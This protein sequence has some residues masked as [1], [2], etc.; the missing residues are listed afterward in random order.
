MKG[1]IN[2]KSISLKRIVF[3]FLLFLYTGGFVLAQQTSTAGENNSTTDLQYNGMPVGG[4]CTGRV[5]LGGYG[6]LWYRDIFNIKRIETE[7][8]GDTPASV[9]E[10]TF[11]RAVESEDV[12]SALGL[13]PNSETRLL[14]VFAEVKVAERKPISWMEKFGGWKQVIQ[15]SKWTEGSLAS[16]T[17]DVF[18]PGYYYID[19]KYRGKGKLVWNISTD[20]GIVVQNQQAATEKYRDYPMGILEFKKPGKHNIKV[21]LVDGV[22]D[23]SSLESVNIY[24]NN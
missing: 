4:I 6:Q 16:R 12:D 11:S 8:P 7:G 14:S 19:L 9:I 17:M 20:E 24:S 3:A 23:T 13:A 21:S 18:Q 2:F 15:I 1:I 5:Y 10:L 22:S